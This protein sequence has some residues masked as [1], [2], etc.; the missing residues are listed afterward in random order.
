MLASG[1][2]ATVWKLSENAPILTERGGE[3]TEFSCL[4]IGSLCEQQ[5]APPRKVPAPAAAPSCSSSVSGSNI[6]MKPGD[7]GK[8][9]GRCLRVELCER[10]DGGAASNRRPPLLASDRLFRPVAVLT[11]AFLTRA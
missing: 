2:S 3:K 4:L 6:L 8:K 9:K 1:V 7:E 5:G 11:D 10:T